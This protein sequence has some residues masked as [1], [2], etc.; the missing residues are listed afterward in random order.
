MA[1][2]AT[3]NLDSQNETIEQIEKTNAELAQSADAT[4]LIEQ[5]KKLFERAK[6]AETTVK[7]LKAKVPVETTPKEAPGSSVTQDSPENRVLELVGKVPEHL[8]A[9]MATMATYAREHNIPVDDVIALFNVKKGFTV[10]KDEV[11]KYHEANLAARESGTGGN[12]NPATSN[13]G[14]EIKTMSDKD[15]EARVK[16]LASQGQL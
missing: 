8:K 5:N 6:K 3:E 9:E 7:E 13:D 11:E 16:D 10:P 14:S 4:K 1:D 15:L 2:E 12:A